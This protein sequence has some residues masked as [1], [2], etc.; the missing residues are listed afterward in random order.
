MHSLTGA[1]DFGVGAFAGLLA[2]GGADLL[3]GLLA[4][5]AGAA[6]AAAALGLAPG[7]GVWFAFGGRGRDR[8]QRRAMPAPRQDAAL[9]AL[10]APMPGAG[11]RPAAAPGAPRRD[12]GTGPSAAD[13][14][15]KKAGGARPLALSAPG[16]WL[17]ERLAGM[18]ALPPVGAVLAELNAAQIGMKGSTTR[19]T[20]LT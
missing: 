3:L 9:D 19:S 6:T 7:L 11:A 10:P 8:A 12:D 17:S 1:A 13:A 15:R 18:R 4:G 2:I 16:A 20:I 5:A 14:V